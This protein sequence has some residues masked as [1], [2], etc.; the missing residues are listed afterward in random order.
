MITFLNRLPIPNLKHYCILSFGFLVFIS[1][2]AQ[3][4]FHDLVND[5]YDKNFDTE[6]L[7]VNGYFLTVCKIIL[8]EPWCIWVSL[9]NSYTYFNSYFIKTIIIYL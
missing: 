6:S 4:I 7:A 2:Y 3:K 5:N 8:D 9:I 1:I